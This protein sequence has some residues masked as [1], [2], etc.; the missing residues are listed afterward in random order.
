VRDALGNWD[1]TDL[2]DAGIFKRLRVQCPAEARMVAEYIHCH[3]ENL[4][5]V[6][7]ATPET[8]MDQSR[9]VGPDVGLHPSHVKLSHLHRL[10]H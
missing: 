5:T 4:G 6:L 3:G 10:E 1:C 7:I 9:R 8:W 2:K